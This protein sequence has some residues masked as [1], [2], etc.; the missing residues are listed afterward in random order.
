MEGHGRHCLQEV[1]RNLFYRECTEDHEVR[2]MLRF[3]TG[4]Y[5]T[6]LDWNFKVVSDPKNTVLSFETCLKKVRP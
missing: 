3:T 2:G 5:F 6:E 1:E 4:L